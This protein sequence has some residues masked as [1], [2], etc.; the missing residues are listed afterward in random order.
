MLSALRFWEIL[1]SLLFYL[2]ELRKKKIF[3]TKWGNRTK[4]CAYVLKRKKKF[5]IIETW[6]KLWKRIN[7]LRPP[8]TF[9]QSSIFSII[10]GW[11]MKESKSFSNPKIP[12]I[13]KANTFTE[14]CLQALRLID[15]IT[16]L[17]RKEKNNSSALVKNIKWIL[18]ALESW[19]KRKTK[20]ASVSLCLSIL[21][22]R[23][24]ILFSSLMRIRKSIASSYLANRKKEIIRSLTLFW[25]NEKYEKEH[26]FIMD[27]ISTVINR[28]WKI[29][30]H[31]D[32]DTVCP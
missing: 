16:F 28:M 30:L 13:F 4:S 21:R 29:F 3:I 8:Q 22:R 26:C 32:C 1:F 20:S 23:K 27:V 10:S 12:K 19:M 31:L 24:N 6:R 25:S 2:M 17:I 18:W 5:H 9:I 11:D 7:S 15:N 14:T